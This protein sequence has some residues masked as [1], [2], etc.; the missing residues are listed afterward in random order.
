M[1]ISPSCI[2]IVRIPY[3]TRVAQVVRY[4]QRGYLLLFDELVSQLHNDVGGLGVER[5]GV[6][7]QK[8]KI[9]AYE[10]RHYHSQ[11]LTL[12]AGERSR[13]RA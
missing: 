9:R 1:I 4:H 11:R 5:G 13:G 3:S 7:V 8:Q 2:I 12:T 10:G 6:F